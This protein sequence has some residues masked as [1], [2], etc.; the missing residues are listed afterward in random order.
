MAVPLAT[1][2]SYDGLMS[3]FR[4]LKELEDEGIDLIEV[5][6]QD[7]H[8]ESPEALQEIVRRLARDGAHLHQEL[9]YYLTYRRFSPSDAA[10][11]WGDIMGHKRALSTA[12]GRHVAFRVAALDWFVS[13]SGSGTEGEAASTKAGRLR[14][15][16]LLARPEF[17][18]LL[19]YVNID[20][21]T[22]AYSRRY[23]NEQLRNELQRAKRYGGPLSLLIVDVDDLK[24]VNDAHGHLEGDAILRLISRLLIDSTRENDSVCRFG[25]D[26]FAV[27]LPETN[28]REA[29]ATGERIRAAASRRSGRDGRGSGQ[30]GEPSGFE[31]L[32]RDI[33]P[34]TESPACTLSIGGASYPQTCDDAE[35]LV[36]LA[37]QMCLDAKRQGKNR[38]LVAGHDRD[39]GI[40]LEL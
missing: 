4:E 39:V 27:L 40:S 16:R 26:E 19:S 35:E 12:L 30:T 18:S 3:L 5:L 31:K 11:I 25:G 32:S 6:G 1:A 17:E 13:P 15:V 33:D 10:Q 2:T 14:G 37:D 8:L 34:P 9:L 20:E 23:F 22:G 38:V 24:S 7:S 29:Y 28:T 36:A 21:V